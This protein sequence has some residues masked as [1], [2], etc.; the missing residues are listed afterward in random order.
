ML[1][2]DELNL[3]DIANVLERC[4]FNVCTELT[5]GRIRNVLVGGMFEDPNVD[6]VLNIKGNWYVHD[7]K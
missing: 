1:F 5:D 4:G 7:R 2:T 6:V 3:I